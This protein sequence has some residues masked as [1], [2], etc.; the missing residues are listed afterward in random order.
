MYLL[1]VF[2]WAASRDLQPEIDI[3]LDVPGDRKYLIIGESVEN[4]LYCIVANVP[5]NKIF[6]CLFSL[7]GKSFVEVNAQTDS[8]YNF[9]CQGTAANAR[10]GY[11]VSEVQHKDA[12]IYK[13]TLESCDGLVRSTLYVPVYSMSLQHSKFDALNFVL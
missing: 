2:H 11:N 3:K 4:F 1:L 9:A 12:G 6:L 8:R 7:S 10:C 5:I 13:C